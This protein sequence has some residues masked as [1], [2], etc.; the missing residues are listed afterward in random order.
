MIKRML[1]LIFLFSFSFINVKALDSVSISNIILK[2]RSENT[3]DDL[4]IDDNTIK[5]IF[6]LMMLTVIEP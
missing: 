4:K 2:E 1:L 5:M 3:L 6:I